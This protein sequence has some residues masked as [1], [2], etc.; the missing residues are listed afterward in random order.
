MAVTAKGRARRANRK[1]L[2]KLKRI[3]EHPGDAPA[4]AAPG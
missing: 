4:A 2:A 3:M 1:D